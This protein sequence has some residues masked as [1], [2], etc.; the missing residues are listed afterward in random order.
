MVFSAF[1][2]AGDLNRSLYRRQ[3]S[4][5]RILSADGNRLL[6]T[7]HNDSGMMAEGPIKVEL[8]CGDYQIVARANGYGTITVP[9]VLAP[10]HLTTVHLEGSVW[11]PRS[12]P[13]FQSD[14]VRLPSGEIV[15]WRAS[16]PTQPKAGAD[17]PH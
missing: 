5:Y 3:H 7:V 2:T 1:D 15:G 6:K 13:I 16:A 12:S 17:H 10:G 4:D 11:W 9:V 14:P 8:P